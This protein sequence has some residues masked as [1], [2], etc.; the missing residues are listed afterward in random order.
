MDIEKCKEC[1]LYRLDTLS[2]GSKEHYC[3]PPFMSGLLAY[4]IPC[5][6]R[7]KRDCK[8]IWEYIDKGRAILWQNK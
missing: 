2:D 6:N 5:K 1:R 3:Y 7:N 8:M 4:A